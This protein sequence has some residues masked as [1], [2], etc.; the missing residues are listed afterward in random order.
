MA[1]RQRRALLLA[2]AAALL[3]GA[4][5]AAACSPLNCAPSQFSLAGGTMLGFRTAIDKPVRVV[6]LRTGKTR[7]TLPAG[8][9][10]GNTL[11]HQAPYELV[12]TNAATDRRVATSAY[13]GGFQLV[14]VS[15]EGR[16]AV[17]QDGST[18][19]IVSPHAVRKL[20]QPGGSWQF[21]ALHGDNLFAIRYLKTGGYQVRLVKVGTGRVVAHVLKDVIW[22][23]PFA[24]LSSPDGQYLF[25]LYV[26]ANGAAM[27]HELNLRSA[28]AKCIDL[29]GTG[30]FGAASTWAMALSRD[31]K[32]LWA[33][34]PGYQR[35]VGIDVATRN[36]TSAFS[37]DLPYWNTGTTPAAVL[38]PDGTHLALADGETVAVVD[39]DARKLVSRTRGR[40][41]A[42]GYS[43]DGTHLWRLKT[44]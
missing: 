4:A 10:A 28:A 38:A 13:P 34:S 37:I 16:R 35:A 26:G 39:L 11:V 30:D 2:A 17:L 18:F 21:D 8:F 9:E 20:R 6:D 36:P 31:G 32:T 5:H 42:L 29:P 43:P 7:W 3:P 33:V 19:A 14:G 1:G 44:S 24:R 25:T 27:I 40:A 23:A 22:G 12:W 41:Q 15:Q